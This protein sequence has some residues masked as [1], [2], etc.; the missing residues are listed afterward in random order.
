MTRYGVIAFVVLL[1]SLGIGCSGDD[2]DSTEVALASGPNPGISVYVVQ[3]LGGGDE[4]TPDPTAAPTPQSIFTASQSR[5]VATASA[6]PQFVPIA[7]ADASADP[8]TDYMLVSVQIAEEFIGNIE[9]VELT[10]DTDAQDSTNATWCQPMS[11]DDVIEGLYWIKLQPSCTAPSYRDPLTEECVL[12]TATCD[13]HSQACT[14]EDLL[15]FS[16]WG[17]ITTDCHE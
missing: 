11:R 2:D 3:T 12:A 13:G 1:S 8:N 17:G 15:T 7:F 14:R 6:S 16:L 10:V 9:Q 4:G 5:P